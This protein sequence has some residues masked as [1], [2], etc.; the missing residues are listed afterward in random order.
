MT[1]YTKPGDFHHSVNRLR[2]GAH[3]LIDDAAQAAKKTACKL[4][5]KNQKWQAK[6]AELARECRQFIHDRPAA[7]LGLA[8]LAGLLFSRVLNAL[9]SD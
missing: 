7:A 8:A 3:D 4:N 2:C 6:K 1:R 9:S 5:R